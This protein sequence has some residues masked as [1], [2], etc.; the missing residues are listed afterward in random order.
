MF[1]FFN[2]EALITF[3]FGEQ[4]L[5]A[6]SLLAFYIAFLGVSVGLGTYYTVSTLFVLHR[7]NS[8]IRSTVEGSVLN[9]GLNLI[10][11]PAYGAAGALGATG[12]VMVYMALRQLF[13]IQ[14]EIDIRPVFPVIGGCFLFAMAAMVPVWIFS[15]FLVD[16]LILNGVVYMISF[17]LLLTWRK[18]FTEDHRQ[19][20]VEIYPRLDPWIRGFVR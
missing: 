8:A 9:V 1:I 11:I 3:V 20:V 5:P 7:R 18:P 19:F 15:R 17:L 6:G 10:F 16:Q 4:Y 2:A 13:A 14:K 12:S